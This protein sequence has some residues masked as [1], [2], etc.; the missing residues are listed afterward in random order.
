MH[1]LPTL[2]EASGVHIFTGSAAV[3]WFMHNMEGVTNVQVARVS[4]NAHNCVVPLPVRYQQAHVTFCI[5]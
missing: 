4:M 1:L 3:K 5:A 2:Q